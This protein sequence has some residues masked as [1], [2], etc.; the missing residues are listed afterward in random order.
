M[1]I[2]KLMF[3]NNGEFYN[4]FTHPEVFE[5]MSVYQSFRTL[6]RLVRLMVQLSSQ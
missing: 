2:S 5:F 6:K 3:E 1:E 4:E